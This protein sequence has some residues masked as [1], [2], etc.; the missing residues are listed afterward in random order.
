LFDVKSIESP[1]SF[2]APGVIC[3]AVVFPVTEVSLLDFQRFGIRPPERLMNM[4][5]KR[6]CE[7]LAGRISAKTALEQLGVYDQQVI[8]GDSGCP[9][10]PQGIVGSV[11]HTDSLA[12]SCVSKVDHVKALG[13]DAEGILTCELANELA[14]QL[15]TAQDKRYSSSL[16]FNY[17]VTLIFSAKEAIYKAL[18]P[19]V[20]VFFGFEAVSLIELSDAVA[21]FELKKDLTER[22]KEGCIIRVNYVKTSLMVYTIVYL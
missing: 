3:A 4:V 11:T 17:F 16:P 15:L 21:V 6:R 22:W 12:I 7:Y 18:Y 13:V 2:S 20:G 19:S 14:P 1:I 9:V 8:R 10:W 5:M